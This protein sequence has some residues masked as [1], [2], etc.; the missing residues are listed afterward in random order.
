[1]TEQ[2]DSRAVAERALQDRDR[3][4]W[5]RLLWVPLLFLPV[6]DL[7]S[8]ESSPWRVALALLGFGVYLRLGYEAFRSGIAGAAPPTRRLVPALLFLTADVTALT[9]LERSS[10]GTLFPALCVGLARL[11]EVWRIPSMLALTGVAAAASS[12]G[13]PGN[14]IGVGAS[15]FGVGLMMMGMRRLAESNVALHM[16]RAELAQ[17]AVAAERE[18]FARDLHDLLGHSLSVIA[19]KAELAGRLLPARADEA[20]T[21]VNEIEG[22][23]REA[24]REVREAVSGYRRPEL[25]AEVE[26]ARMALEAA[27]V[28]LDVAL[29]DA[30]LPA[31]VE[32]VLAW[33]VR[34]GTTNVIR[35]SGAGRCRIHAHAEGD[36]ASVAI[37]DDGRGRRGAAADPLGNGLAGLRERASALGGRVLAGPVDDGHGFRLEMR[38]SLTAAA[39]AAAP[40]AGVDGAAGP[41]TVGALRADGAP[42]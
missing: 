10:W 26:G 32:A 35:H 7:L 3:R 12:T 1:M 19:L 21:H 4:W 25:A 28:S 20:Q 23:A 14:A 11:P 9:L 18:R 8:S 29:P 2:I 41:P 40:P 17:H 33:T 34:E 5:P 6:V 30:P 16:A 13:G 37:E 36:V 38:V 31:E 42:A 39:A 22:V 15:T 27:G 24:L